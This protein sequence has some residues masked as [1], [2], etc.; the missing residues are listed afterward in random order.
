MENTILTKDTI[1]SADDI[2]KEKVEVPE[3]GGSV[4]VRIMTGLQREEYMTHLIREKEG[5]FNKKGERIEAIGKK[6]KFEASALLACFTICDK[7]GVLLFNKSDV[8]KLGMKSSVALE[9]IVA[10]ANKLNK[11]FG[12]K[13][14][15]E[16]VKNL[17]TPTLKDSVTG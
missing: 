5:S 8:V 3:W 12:E 9:R 15:E 14:I 6:E 1:L 11:M 10:K 4:Y 17:E 7:D 2:R 16:E 13:E